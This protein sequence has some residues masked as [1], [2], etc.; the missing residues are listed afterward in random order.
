MI[1]AIIQ[2]RLGSKRFPNKVIKKVNG[3]P[4]IL[5]MIDRLSQSSMID[6]VVVATTSSPI[7][8]RLNELLPTPRWNVSI[9][10]DEQV[11]KKK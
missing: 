11:Q 1:A 8:D 3:Y 6:E 5:F 4:L 10:N 9:L 7:D 2:A